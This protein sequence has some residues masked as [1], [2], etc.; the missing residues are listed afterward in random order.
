MVIAFLLLVYNRLVLLRVR[1]TVC[2]NGRWSIEL[3]TTAISPL[4]LGGRELRLLELWLL[5]VPTV[6]IPYLTEV[7]AVGSVVLP[8]TMQTLTVS[9]ATQHVEWSLLFHSVDLACSLRLALEK[10]SN[11][12]SF[13][14]SNANKALT[15]LISV[16]RLLLLATLDAG[17][18][19]MLSMVAF[20]DIKVRSEKMINCGN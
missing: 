5:L 11:T 18:E 9:G 16:S 6:I 17:D 14:S 8:F 4:S 10:I 7:L 20:Y 2:L 1:S 15:L 19:S 3:T 13:T 12:G